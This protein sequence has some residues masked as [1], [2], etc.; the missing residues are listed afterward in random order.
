MPFTLTESSGVDKSTFDFSRTFLPPSGIP[1]TLHRTYVFYKS[2]Y[3]FELNVTIQNSVNDVPNLKL[4]RVRLHPHDGSADRASVPEVGRQERLPQLR[5]G[6]TR[7]GR[8]RA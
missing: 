4:R 8:T 1:F 2:E 7:S 3:L 6:P 5:C